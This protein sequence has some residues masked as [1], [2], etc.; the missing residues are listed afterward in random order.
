MIISVSAFDPTR[1]QKPSGITLLVCDSIR[2]H[3]DIT[4]RRIRLI[5]GSF[6]H[7]G[8]IKPEVHA[9]VMTV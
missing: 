6:S 3:Q 2:L 4:K 7:L 1:H 9:R 8:R 5:F